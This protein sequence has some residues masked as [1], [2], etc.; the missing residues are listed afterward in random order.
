MAPRGKA[1]GPRRSSIAGRARCPDSRCHVIRRCGEPA[2]AGTS[3]WI[4]LV[5][6]ATLEPGMRILIHAGAGGVGSMAM[7]L[8]KSLGRHVIA[9]CSP[10][11]AE[12]VKILGAS[13]TIAYD[14]VRFEERRRTCRRGFRPARRRGSPAQLS[15]AAPGRND[16]LPQCRTHRGSRQGIRGSGADG[17]SPA[18]P[19]GIVGDRRTRWHYRRSSLLP[20]KR[21][22]PLRISPRPI[23]SPMTGTCGARS[24]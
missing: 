2:L 3:A 20:W 13:E 5:E 19:E 9:T 24:F 14:E 12:Y 7:Q 22:S 15:D 23:G 11:N 16:G 6:T 1:T 10:R 21:F 8:A 18:E 17:T 4:G